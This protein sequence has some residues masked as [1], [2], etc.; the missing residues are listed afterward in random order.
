MDNTLLIPVI[1]LGSTAL[2]AGLYF[3]FRKKKQSGSGVDPARMKEMQDS[4]REE[5]DQ[6]EHDKKTREMMRQQNKIK[7]GTN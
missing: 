4:I 5:M 3:L 7:R 2:I 6:R 1:L